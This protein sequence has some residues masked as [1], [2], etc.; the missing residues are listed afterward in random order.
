MMV[1]ASAAQKTTVNK[2][3]RRRLEEAFIQTL[4]FHAQPWSSL[5]LLEY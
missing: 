5:V 1:A 2:R 4:K 3:I